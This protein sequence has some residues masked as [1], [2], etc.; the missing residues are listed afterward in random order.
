M[1]HI[2]HARQRYPFARIEGSG[3]WALLVERRGP[4]ISHVVLFETEQE[5]MASRPF[6]NAN[7]IQDVTP[8]PCP[9]IA[10]DWED[11]QWERKQKRAEKF[12][13]QY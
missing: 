10:D 1:T 13:A 5:A 3:R 9:D 7:I 2:E 12:D 8:T 6:W 11:R 4:E